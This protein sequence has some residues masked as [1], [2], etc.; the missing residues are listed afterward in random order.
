MIRSRLS[1]CLAGLALS[2]ALARVVSAVPPPQVA[3]AFADAL[4]PGAIVV[5]SP[6]SGAVVEALRGLRVHVGR[7]A[8]GAAGTRAWIRSVGAA[9]GLDLTTDDVVVDGVESLA[10]GRTRV[11]LR[12][13]WRGIPVSG[14][15]ARA[16]LSAD[17]ELR[18]IAST[19]SAVSPDAIEPRVGREHALA[20][21]ATAVGADLSRQAGSARLVIRRLAGVDRLVWEVSLERADGAPVRV[22]VSALEGRVLELDPGVA[23]ATGLAYATDPRGAF[24]EVQL[25]RLLPA[26]GLASHA[27]AIEDQ[28]GPKITPLAPGDYRYPP[29]DPGFDQVNAYWHADR[30]VNEYLGGLGYAGPRD[31]FI[32]RVHAPLEPNVAL[33]SGRFVHLGRPIPGFTQDASR[34]HDLIYH[35]LVHAVLY[36]EDVQPGG[37]RREAGAMHEALADYFAA[38]YTSD[39]AIG[40]W[41]YL[42]FP[43]GATRVDMPPDP[44]NFAHYDQVSFASAPTSSVWA[45]SMILSSALWD[46]RAALGPTCDSLVLEAMDYLP[47]VPTWAHFANALLQAD[48]E[49][50]G[51]RSSSAITGAL[52]RR[53]IR[54]AAV[55][56]FSGPTQLQPGETGEFRAEPCCGEVLGRYQWQAQTVCRGT[57]CGEW[58]W[59]GEG[60]TLRV[61]F[62]DETLLE[63][64]VETPWGDTLRKSRRIAL[65]APSLQ[66]QGPSRLVQRTRGSWSARVVAAA[67]AR[68]TWERQW[69]RPNAFFLFIGDGADVSFDA[70]TSFVLRVTLRDGLN[71]TVQRTLAVETFR[72]RALSD[73]REEFKAALSLRPGARWGEVRLQLVQDQRLRMEVLD[74]SGRAREVLVDGPATRG[75]RVLRFDASG[76]EPGVYLLRVRQGGDGTVLRF[77]VLR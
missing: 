21:A 19:L 14:G 55:A 28:Q 39:P 12:Q 6:A 69:Q 16:M 2:F 5:S 59:L 76:F 4:P 24:A 10:A 23:R 52:L 31:S 71:R 13:T 75:T 36:G 46:L 35:E 61:G 1:G 40:E 67:P 68:V 70:D 26:E 44:W 50:H 48:A 41:A 8:E 18:A 51:G 77:V 66:L 54:G 15:D 30:F 74:V 56:D 11:T 29:E 32:V 58:R 47:T 45:N 7:G 42:L 17:G 3:E 62:G 73:V 22:W 38:A 64:R 53:G 9:F 20:V 27:L 25:E 65:R 43:N 63:L 34:C 60:R 72:D 37:T 33:T 57:P 49:L